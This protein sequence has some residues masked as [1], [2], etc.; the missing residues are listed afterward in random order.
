[1]KSLSPAAGW[2]AVVALLLAASSAYADD[3]RQRESKIPRNISERPLTVTEDTFSVYGQAIGGQLTPSNGYLFVG[4]G[5][6]Y[7]ISN[8]FQV[9]LILIRLNFAPDSNGFLDPIG[10]MS[11]RFIKG[12]FELAGRVFA[13]LPFGDAFSAG[14]ALPMLFRVA[15]YLRIDLAPEAAV[16][17]TSPAIVQAALP[18][19]LR[20]QLGEAMAIG[21]STRFY[22][23]NLRQ[24]NLLARVGGRFTYTFGQNGRADYDLSVFFEAPSFAVT[25]P[26]PTDVFSD[27][28]FSFGLELRAFIEDTVD[29]PF[30]EEL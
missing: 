7:G 1:M 19:L 27:H 25:G 2:A 4:S 29:S 3:E 28:Y 9:E 20:G 5:A 22:F 6:E 17:A 8:D 10:G 30:D 13:T 21:A 14:L 18:V 12:P 26:E 15:G 11:Y 16:S 24:N 23:P